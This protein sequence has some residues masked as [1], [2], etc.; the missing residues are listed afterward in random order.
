MPT[1]SPNQGITTP[2]DADTADAPVAFVSFLA[3]VEPRLVQRYASVADRTTRNPTPTHGQL[4]YLI[5]LKRFER[6]TTL[7]VPTAGYQATASVA[8]SQTTAS[9]SYTALATAGPA[10]TISTDVAAEVTVSATL[11][12]SGANQTWMGFAVSSATTLASAEVRSLCLAGTVVQRASAKFTV[13]L[14]AGSNIFTAQYKVNA[15]T[16]TFVDREITVRPL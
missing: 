11:S 8:T 14:N 15:G 10:I 12:N 5:D 1:N 2:V 13:A 7:W 6:F 3:G 4:S 16:G 9:T